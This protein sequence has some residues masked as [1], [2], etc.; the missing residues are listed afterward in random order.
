MPK[1]KDRM[2]KHSS[3][4]IE[5]FTPHNVIARARAVMGG[6]DLDPASC[7]RANVEVVHAIRFFDAKD[8]GFLRPWSRG[9][10]S[11]RVWLNPP[12]GK[13]D[14]DGRAVIHVTLKRAG[15]KGAY[16]YHDGTVCTARTQ[17][18]AK[19]WW[20]KLYSEWAAGNVDQACFM[21]FNMEIL[22]TTQAYPEGDR[23]RPVTDFPLCIPRA[24]LKFLYVEAGAE[25]RMR[26][27][28]G[29][30]HA[31]VIAFLP[32]RHAAMPGLADFRREFHT[33]G[34]VIGSAP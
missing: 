17:S 2:A 33:L 19:A 6:I 30:T 28:G 32:S 8:N 15:K 5:H 29:P 27:G 1:S 3:E 4:H 13:C 34:A 26:E 24:R 23:T 14:P 25:S 22:Q 7:E 20:A 11:S 31:N 16:L 18:S 9:G 21:G 12:G 10:S